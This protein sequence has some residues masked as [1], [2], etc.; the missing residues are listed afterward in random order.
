MKEFYNAASLYEP[1]EHWLSHGLH[2][3]P[4]HAT[5]THGCRAR[6]TW[7][8]ELAYKQAKEMPLAVALTIP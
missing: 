5:D 4:L 8:C 7:P 6:A 3:M 1:N 2:L